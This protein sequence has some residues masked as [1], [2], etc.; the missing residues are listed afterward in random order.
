[1]TLHQW[2]DDLRHRNCRIT[3]DRNVI[4]VHGPA[5]HDTDRH[6]IDRHRHALHIAATG[7]H[8]TWWDHISG[9]AD[10]VPTDDQIPWADDGY[11]CATCGQPAPHLDPNLLPWCDTHHQD[12]ELEQE[13][14]A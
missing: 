4:I 1:V 3:I 6:H 8:P 5:A 12:D 9:R 7:T 10:T 13:A 11:A 14:A 2:L